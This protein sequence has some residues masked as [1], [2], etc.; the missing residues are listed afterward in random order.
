[1]GTI[2]SKLLLNAVISLLIIAT[3][4][5]V[6]YADLRRIIGLQEE[7]AK[8]AE[9]TLTISTAARSGLSFYWGT[10]QIIITRDFNKLEKEWPDFKERNLKR[11]DEMDK[12]VKSAEEKAL[13]QETRT[14]VKEIIA[15]FDSKVVPV[16]KSSNAVTPEVAALE[17]DMNR[18][19]TIIRES[20][21]KM[22]ELLKKREK[23]IEQDLNSLIRSTITKSLVIG[24]FGI[25][26]QFGMAGFI[27]RSIIIPV[28]AMVAIVK[29]MAQGEG[30]LTK[31][32]GYE[33]KDELG[34]LGGYIDQFVEKLHDIVR[35]VIKDSIKVVISSNK[36]HILA[37]AITKE[38][39]ALAAQA[40]TVATASEEMSATSNDIAQNCMQAAEG[41][42]VATKV[43]A[44]GSL[45]VQET[46]AGM[47]RI[48]GM[49][50]NAA[51][52][53]DSLGA[54][55]DQIGAIVGTI[56]D[57]ADQ[58]NLLALNAAIEAAR[59]G[60]QG[61]GFAVVADEVRALAE[62]TTKATNEISVMIKS[63]QSETKSAVESMEQGVHEVEKGSS[64][65]VRSGEALQGILDQINSVNL[66]IS[67]IATAAEEQT[68]T[69][70]E[71]SGNILDITEI[72]RKTS[73]GS[74]EAARSSNE[75]LALSEELMAI[76]A[77]FRVD[78]DLSMVLNRA[79]SAHMLFVGKIKAHLDGFRKVDPNALPTHLT[80][81]FGKWCQTKGQETCGSSPAYREIDAPH[82]K[83][84]ELGKQAVIAYNSGDRVRAS[85]LCGE[86]TD[87]SLKLIAILDRLEGHKG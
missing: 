44:E 34:A 11:L 82:A 35:N 55:S 84:H 76:L 69:T 9:D 13:A 22:L 2:K 6:N 36:V 27:Y 64:D 8:C 28:S 48:A 79:K 1:M 80:C 43:A 78:E 49:V 85:D 32:V 50:R 10:A 38:S 40:A 66:Q 59:A 31:K 41:G 14:S 71:I 81:A 26:I 51:T 42:S 20:T 77:K 86:M 45:I 83:V 74:H 25:L 46:V 57:I 67:Q 70:S 7:V 68:A 75:L 33:G 56:Q 53:V 73:S 52:T 60:E 39:D 15:T 63:I 18:H 16:L 29:E 37:E 54:R 5:A 24:F 58:T 12:A 72:A 65:A 19:V 21:F 62:R 30:D 3:I 47:N 17:R 4:I 61:R 87:T 23:Q